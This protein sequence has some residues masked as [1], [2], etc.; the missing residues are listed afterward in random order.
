[1]C[2]SAVRSSASARRTDSSFTRKRERRTER[3]VQLSLNRDSG[4]R[5]EPREEAQQRRRMERDAAGGRSEALPR[6]MQEYGAAAAGGARPR[7]VVDLDD[8][9]VEV[10]VAPQPVARRANAAT[11][12]P[13]VASVG[14]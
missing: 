5:P 9:V 4:P 14:R 3:P 10:I 11:D 13:V 12:M 2:A 1:M 7:V 8:E 6:H